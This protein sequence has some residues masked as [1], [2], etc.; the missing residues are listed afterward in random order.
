MDS[1]RNSKNAEIVGL[2][3]LKPEYSII[4]VANEVV[5]RSSGVIDIN[6]DL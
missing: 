1:S 5:G 6:I 3:L 4:F 2:H